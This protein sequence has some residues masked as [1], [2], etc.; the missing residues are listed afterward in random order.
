MGEKVH[1]ARKIDHVDR[2][3]ISFLDSLPPNQRIGLRVFGSKRDCSPSELVIP[4]ASNN[5][6]KIKQALPW[7]TPTGRTPLTIALE[8]S[9]GDF[10]PN[11]ELDKQIILLSDGSDTCG[12]NPCEAIK[13][14]IREN[15][16]LKIRVDVVAVVIDDAAR[17]QLRC[18]AEASEGRFLEIEGSDLPDLGEAL[19]S[20]VATVGDL[21]YRIIA[22]T[23]GTITLFIF[24]H[25][26]FDLL[27]ALGRM[28]RTPAGIS[29]SLAF[30][31]LDGLLL[32]YIFSAALP[33]DRTWTF[34]VLA[35]L[36]LAA[37]YSIIA[38]R[39]QEEVSDSTQKGSETDQIL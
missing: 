11:M 22:A 36:C 33:W 13:E 5:A 26:L 14:I 23:I 17:D 39:D 35:V 21:L 27:T 34:I 9:I 12:G 4:I 8:E 6:E 16:F 31:F 30:V 24:A 3:I 18:I 19:R 37:I 20:L 2:G 38:C 7:L 32:S 10:S 28:R 1:G 29:A 25:I 15:S